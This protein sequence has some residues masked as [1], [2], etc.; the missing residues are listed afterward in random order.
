MCFID[1]KVGIA[2]PAPRAHKLT[3]E[4]VVRGAWFAVR[5]RRRVADRKFKLALWPRLAD[6]C[7]VPAGGP[8]AF[9]EDRDYDTGRN[10]RACCS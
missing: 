7:A 5:Y 4:T 9:R 3:P 10:G 8:P 1:I 2:K 6:Y